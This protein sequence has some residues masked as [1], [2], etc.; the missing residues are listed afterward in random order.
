MTASKF[1]TP[2]AR[3][4]RSRTVLFRAVGRLDEN[5]IVFFC[6]VSTDIYNSIHCPSFAASF[7][8]VFHF[9]IAARGPLFCQD[10]PERRRCFKVGDYLG[11]DGPNWKL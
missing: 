10:V 5:E 6:S 3:A 7:E 8:D 1:L 2:V 9:L 11:F 4:K